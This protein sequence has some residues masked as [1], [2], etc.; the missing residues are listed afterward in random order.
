ML[1]LTLGEQLETFSDFTLKDGYVFLQCMHFKQ[2]LLS[3]IQIDILVNIRCDAELAC[4]GGDRK[5]SSAL[6][7]V[8]RARL[9]LI[10]YRLL[11]SFCCYSCAI[12]M[13]FRRRRR[14][15]LLVE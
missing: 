14:P 9:V 7:D 6:Y 1:I 15:S 11:V 12:S 13:A 5:R 2:T 4:A 3:L 10:L 8:T